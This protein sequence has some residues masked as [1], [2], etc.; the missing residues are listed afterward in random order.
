[1]SRPSSGSWTWRRASRT[2]ASVR[3]IMRGWAS[4]WQK[5]CRKP[6]SV[7]RDPRQWGCV[8]RPRTGAD[9]RPRCGR[10]RGRWTGRPRRRRGP[11]GRPHDARGHRPGRGWPCATRRRHR[12]A[13]PDPP[14]LPD[15]VRSGP[16]RGDHDGQSRRER[17]EQGIGHALPVAGQ[18]EQVGGPQGEARVR[19]PGHDVDVAAGSRGDRP[20]P[21]RPADEEE[22]QAGVVAE[23]CPGRAGG[24]RSPSP[25]RSARGTG[26]PPRPRAARAADRAAAR[27]SGPAGPTTA[28]STPLGMR[29]MRP[30]RTPT[31]TSS[32][33]ICRVEAWTALARPQRGVPG[34]AAQPA[35]PGDLATG[36]GPGQLQVDGPPERPADGDRD[37]GLQV[38]VMDVDDVVLAGVSGQV[39]GQPRGS[40]RA[41]TAGRGR[42]AAGRP[43]RPRR[44]PS[45]PRR[46]P[47]RRRSPG[48]PGGPARPPAVGPGA[49]RHRPARGR[50]RGRRQDRGH[51]LSP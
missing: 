13:R 22:R 21:G 48:G 26:R 15:P 6:R 1:M 4:F 10:R 36:S 42:S 28:G 16:D 24:R 41:A 8:T 33:A 20:Q 47:D 49:R 30:G 43:A 23:R 44:D 32:A 14:V 9:R 12:R 2:A 18:H 27:A 11:P 31:P 40:G 25:R 34:P 7:P 39:P 38:G 45:G 29:T 50:S 17:L 51:G 37:V 5:S 35:Q 3:A 19:Q 46:R